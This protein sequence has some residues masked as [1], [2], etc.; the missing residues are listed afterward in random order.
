[1]DAIEQTFPAGTVSGAPKTRAIE[2]IDEMELY[3]SS[4]GLVPA[5]LVGKVRVD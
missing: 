2:I 5:D 3:F 1:M 4:R